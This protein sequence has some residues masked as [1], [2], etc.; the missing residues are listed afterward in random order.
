MEDTRQPETPGGHQESS[1]DQGPLQTE[2]ALDPK[3][4]EEL[5]KFFVHNAC[6]DL[7]MTIQQ[8]Q[9]VFNLL[10]KDQ[11]LHD[12]L[13]L[14]DRQLRLMRVEA[15]NLWRMVREAEHLVKPRERKQPE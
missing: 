1:N 12:R 11:F 7:V 8:Q 5:F 15:E 10:F 9:Q 14:I 3:T 13:M 2:I 6:S 4:K